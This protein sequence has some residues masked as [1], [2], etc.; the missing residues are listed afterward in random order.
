MSHN[1]QS[2]NG[3]TQEREDLLKKLHKEGLSASQIAARITSTG[4]DCSRNA[5]IGK[6]NRMG[7][8]GGDKPR[9]STRSP[10]K[11]KPRAQRP[12]H[13]GDLRKSAK[14]FLSAEPFTPE[15]ELVIPLNERK[16][17]ATLEENDCRWPI[18]DPQHADFHFC[19]KEKAHVFEDGAKVYLPLPYCEHHARRAY[20]PPKLRSGL[21]YLQT[22][23]STSIGDGTRAVD[24]LLSGNAPINTREKADA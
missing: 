15:P 5:V 4:F 11:H 14:L 9:R 3:W 21:I 12:P 1:N 7:L 22:N 6:A 17:V 20:V 16:T 8:T 10:R 13:Y 23:K 24:E 2:R 19:G 18:G